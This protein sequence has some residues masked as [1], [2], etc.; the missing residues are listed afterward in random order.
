MPRAGGQAFGTRARAPVCIH[1][2]PEPGRRF[3]RKQNAEFSNSSAAAAHT[4]TPAAAHRR[5]G[6]RQDLE[7]QRAP[8]D[9]A[10]VVD[11]K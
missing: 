8:H 3:A 5:C 4:H 10:A 9:A 11:L 6:L 7:F 2:P 1:H